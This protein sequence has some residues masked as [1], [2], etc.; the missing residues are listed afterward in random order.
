M[1][2]IAIVTDSTSFLP[3]AYVR[4]YNITVAPQVLIWGEE[5]FRDGV[6]IQPAEFYTRLKTAKTMPSTSQVSPASMQAIFKPLVEQGFEVLGLFVSSKLSGTIPSAMQARDA[7]ETAGSKVTIVDSLAT[8]MA[9]SLIVLAA[10]R[11]AEQGGTL[12]ECLAAAESTRSNTGLFFAVDT[13]EFLHRGGR[14]GGAQRFIG[15]ALNLKPILA[16]KD[17]R[18]EGVERIRTKSKAHDRVLELVAENV[19]GKSNIRI[20]ALHA[21]A[22]EDA[23]TLLD[24]AAQQSN[25]V[26]TIFAEVSPVVGTHTGPGTIGLAFTFD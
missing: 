18:V 11:A 26:E 8:S 15:S 24:R 16:L 12:K 3:E 2:K 17:G 23:K 7:M 21:N 4:K 6:D 25:P 9:L 22:S 1:S 10:A 14:I 5:T 20:A 13:L 19:Q